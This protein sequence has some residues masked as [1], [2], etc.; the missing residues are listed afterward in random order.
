MSAQSGETLEQRLEAL[1]VPGRDQLLAF[2]GDG[3]LWAGDVGEDVFELAIAEDLLREPAREALE[4]LARHNGV[5]IAS[6]P[7][8]T[9]KNLFEAYTRDQ[10][11]ERDICAMLTWCYA[12]FTRAE[13]GILTERAFAETKLSERLRSE[14]TPVF[15]LAKR[16]RL[17]ILVVS[18]SPQSIVE[19]AAALWGLLPEQ[20]VASRPAYVGDQIAPRLAD[21]VPYAEQKLIALRQVDA[22]SE[23]VAAFGDN[24]FD[25]ELLTAARLAVAV[26]PKRRLRPRLQELENLFLLAEPD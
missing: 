9:A 26:H 2:D 24:I 22:S 25:W 18:A 10:V 23:L 20:V 14:L 19:Q 8:Q 21:Q 11:P 4:E 6:S 5:R 1:I 3:T 16:H 13:L 15:S 12:G 17:R 7:T